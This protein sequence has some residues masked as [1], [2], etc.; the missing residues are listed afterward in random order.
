MRVFGWRHVVLVCIIER[1]DVFVGRVGRWIGCRLSHPGLFSLTK[2][3]GFEPLYAVFRG[4]C[5]NK[6]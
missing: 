3:G 1:V 5:L 6:R 2:I 4:S